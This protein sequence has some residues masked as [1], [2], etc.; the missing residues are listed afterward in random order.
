MPFLLLHFL[1]VLTLSIFV[2]FWSYALCLC[3]FSVYMK[4]WLWYMKIWLEKSYF[5]ECSDYGYVCMTSRLLS[6]LCLYDQ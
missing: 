3:I 2:K 1:M 6:I 4:I 5:V